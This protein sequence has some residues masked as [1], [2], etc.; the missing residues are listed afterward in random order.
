MLFGSA[1]VYGATGEVGFS[2]IAQGTA[3]QGLAHDP[4]FLVTGW[5]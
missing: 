3:A 5:P 1:L 4:M 2:Q